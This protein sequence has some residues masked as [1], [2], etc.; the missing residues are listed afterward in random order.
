[1]KN[2]STKTTSLL[3]VLL[4][5]LSFT[6]CS[7]LSNSSSQTSSATQAATIAETA[8]TKPPYETVKSNLTLNEQGLADNIDDGAILHAWCWSFNTIKEN[9]KSIADSGFSAIQTS[10]I[11]ECKIGE[12]GGL[13]IGD[14]DT[15]RNNGKWYYHYQ[16]ISFKIGNYQLGTEE[17]FKAMC[18]EAHKYGIKIIVDVIPNHMTGDRGA[19]SKDVKNLKDPFHSGGSINDWNDRKQVTQGD[20]LGLADLNTQNPVIQEAVLDYLKRCVEDGADGFRYDAAKHIELDSDDPAFASEF[21][22]VVTKNGSKFQ[23]GEILQGGADRVDA[24]ATKL[25][26]A[27]SNYGENI[28]QVIMN[29]D[30]SAAII[31]NYNISNIDPSKLVTWV[32]SHD[33]YCNDGS[34]EQLTEDDVKHGWA[35]ITARKGG[36]PLF[37]SRPM[38]SSTDNQ[39]GNNEIGKAGSN[40]YKDKTVVEINKFRNAMIGLDEEI[41]N[42]HDIENVLMIERGTKGVVI[43]SVLNTT[44]NL[45]DVT[46]KL[47]DGTYKDKIS[48]DTFTV[49]NGEFAD[50]TVEENQIIVLY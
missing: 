20:L 38:G 35:I 43:V 11:S 31:E 3:L 13:Q 15:S 23:Y 47:E 17:E 2:R 44:L 26:L 32:E 39:W 46:T 29:S 30:L 33:N 24:Y 7:D 45:H 1:M 8:S 4:L 48:G 36:T 21:W 27:A 49:K 28:R 50:G 16:P 37:Y 12:N 14:T 9:L 19:I 40:A 41:S 18:S 5:A 42:P 34:W 6:A 22:E 25:N 10:P